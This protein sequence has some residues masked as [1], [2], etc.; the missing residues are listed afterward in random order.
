[1]SLVLS[2]LSILNEAE[3]PVNLLKSSLSNE[4][5]IDSLE[6]IEREIR[7]AQ[8]QAELTN[9]VLKLE[10]VLERKVSP[11]VKSSIPLTGDF[12]EVENAFDR[13]DREIQAEL[14]RSLEVKSARNLKSDR[15]DEVDR[16]DEIEE[17]A[18]FEEVEEVKEV[19]RELY[20]HLQGIARCL[21][22]ELID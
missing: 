11:K 21:G 18:R 7:A 6:S 19:D 12:S 10:S 17:F 5:E 9:A 2:A 14:S 1:M 13:I 3:K 15:L 16:V 22:E 4:R 8:G 20:K